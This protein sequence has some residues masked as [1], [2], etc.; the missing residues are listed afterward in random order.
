MLGKLKLKSSWIGLFLIGVMLF[1]TF[2]YAVIQS[3]YPRQR[4]KLPE[5]NIID[6]ELDQNLKNAL[7]NY[8]I[9]FITFD[10]N[11]GCKNCIDQKTYLESVA[12]EFQ[13]QIF[14]E[15]LLNESLIE[16]KIKIESIYGIQELAAANETEV[17]TALCDLMVSPPATCALT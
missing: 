8:G 16:S 2:A 12:N 14:L 3:F 4:V 1:S 13:Q 17:F 6:Y 11:L 7:I 15:E 5:T 10:Y 9:T